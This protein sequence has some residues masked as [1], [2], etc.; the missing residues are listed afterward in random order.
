[1][2][3]N[4]ATPEQIEKIRQLLLEDVSRFNG[5]TPIRNPETLDR[6]RGLLTVHDGKEG[7][8]AAVILAAYGDSSGAEILRHPNWQTQ[9]GI[10]TL[11]AFAAQILI[12][13]VP[14][15]EEIPNW[16]AMSPRL[17]AAVNEVVKW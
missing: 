15:S 10:E 14:P 4:K 11:H 6:L 12:G 1:M 7:F 2:A 17:T 8:Y 5:A 13:Q 3:E 16:Q 9:S